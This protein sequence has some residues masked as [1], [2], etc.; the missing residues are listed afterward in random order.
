MP[1]KLDP[2]ALT[3]I[4]VIIALVPTIVA[5]VVWSTRAT[6]SG[7]GRW[8]AGN[9]LDTLCL[10]LLSLRGTVPDWVS[11]VLANSLALFA[12]ALFYQGARE[13]RGLRLR[14]WP[15]CMI[16]VLAV[17]AVFYYWRVIDAMGPRIFACSI[18]LG[19]FGLACGI[20]LMRNTPKGCGFN[21][22]FTGIVFALTGVPSLS[23]VDRSMRRRDPAI[24]GSV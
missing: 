9:L 14:W 20:T 7:F 18:T 2:R 8:A 11:V 15:E 6:C 12:A 5:A 24:S 13:F 16:M 17:G 3:V 10:A 1:I 21:M 19:C 22:A 23:R 4:S